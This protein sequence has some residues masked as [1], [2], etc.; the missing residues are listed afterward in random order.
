MLVRAGVL[1]SVAMAIVMLGARCAHAWADCG[2]I[3]SCVGGGECGCIC[4]IFDDQ[5]GDYK[6]FIL[7][8][9]V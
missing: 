9:C 5:T 6:G 8:P 2:P 1:A 7:Y 3:D 4:V